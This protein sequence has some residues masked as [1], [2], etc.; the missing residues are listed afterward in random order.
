M[1][2]APGLIELAERLTEVFRKAGIDYAI[3]GALAYGLWGE[4]RGTMDVDVC[5]FVAR[6]RADILFELLESLGGQLERDVCRWQ[7][8][9][10]HYFAVD[11]GLLRV[12]VF[13]PDMLLYDWAFPRRVQ[14]PLGS[15]TAWYWSAEDTLLFKL[16]FFRTKDKADIETLVGVQREN[17]DLGYV[18]RALRDIIDDEQRS[19]WFE[20]LVREVLGGG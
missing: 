6:E 4:P 1:P 2:D 8:N 14:A 10:A 3:G 18:R 15:S 12:D 9:T 17:L 7:L 5:A 19:G 16:I 13:S 11:F 20:D